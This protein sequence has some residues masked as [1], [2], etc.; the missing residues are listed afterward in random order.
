M[1]EAES[2][3]HLRTCNLCESMCGL[4]ITTENGRVVKIRGDSG[5][6]FSQGHIC[7]KGLAHKDL[8]EDPDRL[9]RPLVRKNGELVP[10][11]WN[12]A[13]D[14]CARGLS[15]VRRRHG[16]DS[17][18][19]Y[20][21]NP[22]AHLHGAFLFLAPLFWCLDTKN[23]Y[24]ASS[25][26]Q[27]PLMVAAYLMFGNMALLPIPDVGRTRH[28]LILGGNPLVSGGSIMSSG[29][30]R[31]HLQEIRKRGGRI[32]VVDPYRSKTA[33]HADQH[34][35]IRPGSDVLLLLAMI[36][37][38]FEEGL[39]N[40]GRLA[41]HVKNMTELRRAAAD[42]PPERVAGA[43]EIPAGTIRQLARDFAVA[44]NAVCYGRIG[45]ACQ[46]FGATASWLIYCLNIVCG[47][48]D[49]PGGHMFTKPAADFVALAA[50]VNEHGHLD[51]WRSR[52]RGLPEFAGEFPVAALA[53]EMSVPGEGQ[54]RAL[55]T[56]AGN[57]VLSAPNG[58]LVDDALPELDFM[59]SIDWYV[60]ETTRHADV[61]LP[62]SGF[63][64]HSHYDV[65]L[66]PFAVR[67]RAR[68][69]E[70]V[71]EPP[72]HVM[73]NWQIIRSLVWRLEKN[74]V[75]KALYALATPDR[76]LDLALR[77]GPW[78]DRFNPLGRG[79]SL[80]GLKKSRRGIDLGPLSPCLPRRLFTADRKIDVAPSV[81]LEDLGRV[82]AV[83]FARES[84]PRRFDMLL[85]GRRNLRSNNSWMHNAPSLMDPRNRCTV[86]IHPG[87]ARI[88]GIED[89]DMVRVESRVGAVELP[90]ELTSD[91]MPGVVSIP[92]GW[93]HDRPGVRLSVARK[94]PGVSVNDITDQRLVDAVC[95][96]AVFS[97][98]P[99]RIEPVRGRPEKSR[100]SEKGRDTGSWRQRG[101]SAR[102]SG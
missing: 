5:D 25:A 95:G 8:H 76:M 79:V 53:E 80:K 17:V 22:C 94:Q 35:F 1:E 19:L 58:K 26:D 82:E 43:C 69:D 86:M 88:H 97:G 6:F 100:D 37:T 98:V 48:M 50:L 29:G 3:I 90:A 102:D 67:N 44:D 28:F 75:K 41:P 66:A 34:V 24:S 7:P 74:P 38:V 101:A 84:K 68:Y 36:H 92:H 13:L 55:L 16:K 91:I 87:D 10:V 70:P 60:N 54:V 65:A 40:P 59:A 31:R 14:A 45:T 81:F 47:R 61:I 46:E 64:E 93:G 63:L 83:F 11:S 15:R 21:G 52:V 99:V 23:R 9:R 27:L 57:P 85:I 51:K 89:A 78:G 39:D 42:Y 73:H 20:I 71:F 77:M 4:E 30:P 62:P 56:V 49:E 72:D 96:T 33:R 32:V 12:E 2:N 18:G